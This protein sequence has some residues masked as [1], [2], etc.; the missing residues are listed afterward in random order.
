[1]WAGN[2]AR[3]SFSLWNLTRP[4]L[5]REI[6]RSNTKPSSQWAFKFTALIEHNQ[7]TVHSLSCQTQGIWC[8]IRSALGPK[9]RVFDV[10]LGGICCSIR[11]D[12]I[13][14]IYIYVVYDRC[15]GHTSNHKCY[16]QNWPV[17]FSAVL[18]WKLS[19]LSSTVL[20]YY[21]GPYQF[22]LIRGT[23]LRLFVQRADCW[24]QL[25]RVYHRSGEG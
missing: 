22:E 2:Y 24:L 13:V 15:W 20:V 11:L 14:G 8:S 7:H 17:T 6:V 12:I 10:V 18:G 23:F 5:K 1:M 4:E 16:S 9:H 3:G 25:L 19:A 21:R